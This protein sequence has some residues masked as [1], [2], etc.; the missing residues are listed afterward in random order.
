MKTQKSLTID[1][2]VVKKVHKMAEEDGRTFSAMV[3][4]LL[5]EMIA[6]RKK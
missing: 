4:R 5:V 2:E 1:S 6:I 3:E